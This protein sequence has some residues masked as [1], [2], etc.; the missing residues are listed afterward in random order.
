VVIGTDCTG[1]NPNPLFSKYEI[2]RQS[3]G[4]CVGEKKK[5][6]YNQGLRI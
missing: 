3:C 6:R 2:V 5:G 4:V 1:N